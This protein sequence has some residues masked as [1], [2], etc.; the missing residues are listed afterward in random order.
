MEVRSPRFR[1]ARWGA[2]VTGVDRLFTANPYRFAIFAESLH[3]MS[4]QG[5]R[6]GSLVMRTALLGTM[7]LSALIS[8]YAQSAA[9]PSTIGQPDEISS[10]QFDVASV[11]ENKSGL[12]PAGE[13]PSTNVP[14]GPGDVYSPTGGLFMAKNYPLISYIAFAYKMTDNQLATFRKMAPDWVNSDR[15]NI[16]ARTDKEDVTKDELRLMVR[17]LIKE[18]FGFSA[19]YETREVSVYA[20]K[21]IRPG[22]TGPKLQIHPTGSSCP[23]TIPGGAPDSGPPP[24]ETTSSGFPATCGGLV[25]LPA[26]EANRVNIGARDIPLSLLAN[27]LTGWGQLDHPVKDETGLTGTID[28]DLEY[29]PETRGSLEGTSAA[30]PAGDLGGPTF[31]QALKQQLGLRLES[32]K[33]EVQ[34]IVLDHIEPLSEN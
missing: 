18:R 12:S 34:V 8:M 31:R 15:F 19:H 3:F 6:S 25:I 9:R 13:N 30:S 28:F 20:L 4:N 14:L 16:E 10:L 11:R 32:E 1:I 27:S 33:G 5:I 29:V 21:L 17:S 7:F 22:E 24:S 23:N 2:R 26:H